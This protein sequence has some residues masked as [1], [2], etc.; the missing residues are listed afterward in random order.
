M[1]QMYKVFVNDKVIYF[2]NN[3]ENCGQLTKG[4]TLTF[5]SE[6]IT[7]YLVDFIFNDDK[8]EHIV[9]AVSDYETAFTEFQK[10]F[11][12]IEAA[13][14]IVSNDKDEKLFIYRLDKWDFPK[15]KIEEGEN[16][17]EAA[18]REIEEEC[19]VNQLII[20]KSL[21]DT[22]HLYK[23][24]GDIVFK[25]TYWFETVSSFSGEL[26]PQLEEDITNVEWLSDTQIEEKVLGN[27]YASIK[28]LLNSSI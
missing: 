18:L 3:V 28:T 22:F 27:T 11:K 26:V 24:K 12:T 16:V 15:G 10:Y 14:G 23:F 25:R 5:F 9:I 13:G 20:K 1:L 2:T 8:V 6:K 19:G 4:L 17:E 7:S 21:E